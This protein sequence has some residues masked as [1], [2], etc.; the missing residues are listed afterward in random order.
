M[1][2]YS[3]HKGLCGFWNV[4][5][6]TFHG[7]FAMVIEKDNQ[8]SCQACKAGGSA[9]RYI[10]YYVLNRWLSVLRKSDE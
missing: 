3:I 8:T 7:N 9:L 5:K 6:I 10:M 2:E 1:I 4:H